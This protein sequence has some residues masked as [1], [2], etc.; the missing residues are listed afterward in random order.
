ML[1]KKPATT[2][3]A[4]AKKRAVVKRPSTAASKL[5]PTPESSIVDRSLYGT[6]ATGTPAQSSRVA[7][8]ARSAAK[9]LGDPATGPSRRKNKPSF[10][11]FAEKGSE[12]N[13][14]LT[15]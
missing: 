3:A 8:P 13:M 10:D 15:L 1:K 14:M 2:A 9:K 12:L 6:D 4:P 7:R 5:A 11:G